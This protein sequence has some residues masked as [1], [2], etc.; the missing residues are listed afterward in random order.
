MCRQQVLHPDLDPQADE[1]VCTHGHQ[2]QLLVAAAGGVAAAAAV[3]T[4]AT[5]DMVSITSYM[6]GAAPCCVAQLWVSNRL[7]TAVRQGWTPLHG[8]DLR[9]HPIDWGGGGRGIAAAF[10]AWPAFGEF[11]GAL[12]VLLVLNVRQIKPT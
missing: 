8:H 3:E 5:T 4:T 12:P 10:N 1:P 7:A 11:L 6:V 9:V 2:R